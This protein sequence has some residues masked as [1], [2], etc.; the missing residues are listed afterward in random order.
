VPVSEIFLSIQGE[1]VH[2]GTPSVFL[3]TF[4][5]NLTCTWCDT[6]Y[7]WLNQR[8]ARAHIDYVPMKPE[9]IFQQLM[10]FKCKH[11]VL[12]GGEPLLHQKALSSLTSRL[13]HAGFF[14]EAET[15]GTVT[16][17][18]EFLETVDCFNVSP[19]TSNSLVRESV[20][21]RPS[22]LM[23]F[24]R[25]GKAWFK[26]VVTEPGDL[27]EIEK[28]ISAHQIPRERVL[29]MPEGTDPIVIAE[30]SRWLVEICKDKGFRLG[31]RLHISLFGNR[32]GT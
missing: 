23:A 13:G 20:R 25:S 5:C 4:Y 6:M 3:R 15:N 17:V 12:T 9:Q 18:D 16:P 7:T 31:P 10:A 11:L 30:R 8:E 28:L 2:A 26:F 29:L 27:M 24:V 19:K 1:G 32:R 21:T 22:S 14:I